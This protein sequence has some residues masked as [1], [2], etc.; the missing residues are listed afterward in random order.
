MLSKLHDDLARN[1]MFDLYGLT[2]YVLCKI[3]RMIGGKN[4]SW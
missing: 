3:L 4:Q 1:S 2:A